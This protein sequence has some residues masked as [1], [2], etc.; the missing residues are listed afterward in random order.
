MRRF[1]I[2]SHVV[3]VINTG[4]LLAALAISTWSALPNPLRERAPGI[5]SP[6]KISGLSRSLIFMPTASQCETSGRKEIKIMCEYAAT[7]NGTSEDGTPTRI[8]LNRILISF[9]PTD[10]SHMRVDL[11]F[12]N[13]GT[14]RISD[15]HTPYLVIDDEA[16]LNHVRRVLQQVD[17]RKIAPGQQLTF[18]NH[19]LIGSFRPG[20]Y[21]I[22]LWIP[23]PDPSLKFSSA[24]NFLLSSVGVANPHTG[25]NT[26]AG[27]TVT[28]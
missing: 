6:Q 8:V 5:K 14:T 9:E 4:A 23:D 3:V 16:G 27:F 15:A 20:H 18:S 13:G 17:F 19:L 1:R 12:T 25:L 28:P 26:L 7:P 2:S 11:T 24:H 10:E 21:T 22:Y